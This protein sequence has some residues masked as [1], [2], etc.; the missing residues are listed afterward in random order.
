MK[1]LIE[2]ETLQKIADSIKAGK[3]TTEAIP[4]GN[5]SDEI[6]DIVNGFSGVIDRSITEINIPDKVTKIGDYIFILCTQLSKITFHDNI[7]YIGDYAL[8]NTRI[9]G[10]VS[11]PKNL[12]TIGLFAFRGCSSIEKFVFG[13]K[14]QSID[15]TA[16]AD[17][18]ICLEYDF[19][20]CKSI[21]TLGNN[22]FRGINANAKIIVPEELYTQWASATNWVDWREHIVNTDDEFIVI[23]G[24]YAKVG[25][26]WREWISSDYNDGNYYIDGNCIK[27]HRNDYDPEISQYQLYYKDINGT[28]N[29][30][31]P[32]DKIINCAAGTEYIV[33]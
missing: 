11:L 10:I 20:K 16:F 15:N 6:S 24:L 32:D 14:V 23:N 7:T 5:F 8:A 18:T 3:G 9:S 19:S 22:A 29:N 13:D 2:G 21:P 33:W 25:M 12:T 28:S 1:Y 17:N 4:V 31:Y 30:V 27:D 26:T